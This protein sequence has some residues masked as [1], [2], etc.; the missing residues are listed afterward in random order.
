M[1]SAVMIEPT[2]PGLEAFMI[3]VMNRSL[4]GDKLELAH[5][6]SGQ[7][8][9]GEHSSVSEK[10]MISRKDA[11]FTVLVNWAEPGNRLKSVVWQ[12]T[13]SIFLR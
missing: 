4:I 10:F 3:Q 2:Y 11:A 1:N 13:G 7:I 8:K 6:T 9:R 12:R 5:V